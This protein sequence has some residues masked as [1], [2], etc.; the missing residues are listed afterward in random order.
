MMKLSLSLTRSRLTCIAWCT[1]ALL[2]ARVDLPEF[3]RNSSMAPMEHVPEHSVIARKFFQSDL[4]TLWEHPVSRTSALDAKK[5]TF[6]KHVRS[7]SMAHAL[8]HHS[9]RSS[10]CTTRWRSSYLQESTTT[11]RR[12]SGSKFMVSAVPK[13]L[14]HPRA[15][16]TTLRT[17][18]RPCS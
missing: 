17:P 4:A 7:T 6:P 2:T 15:T 5:F 9:L 3:T 14:T 1:L 16:S 8:V 11:N 13:Y 10:W 12:Y 18:C